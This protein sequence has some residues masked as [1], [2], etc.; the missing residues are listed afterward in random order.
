M[1]HEGQITFY[2]K[3]SDL[4]KEGKDLMTQLQKAQDMAEFQT[5]KI[6]EEFTIKFH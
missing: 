4:Y 3:G 2:L 1:S 6:I 5:F